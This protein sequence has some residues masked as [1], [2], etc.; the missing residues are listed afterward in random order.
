M[1]KKCLILFKWPNYLNKYLISKLSN[2]Y[3]VEHLFISN[4]KNENFSQTVDKIN[5]TIEYKKIEIVF[6]DV[7]FA[8]FMNFFFIN[9]IKKVKKVMVT[10]DDYAVHE[11]NAITANSCDIILC[12]CPLSTLKYREKGYESYWMPPENDANIFKNYNLNK[13]ID[14]LF[15]GQLRNDRK[16]FIDFLIDNGIKVKI[17]GHDS[18]WVTEEE[19]IKLISKSKIVLNFSKSLGETVTN[20]AA[21]DIYKFHYQ[22]KGRLIQSGLCGTLCISEYSPGQEMIFNEKEIP[23]FR[24]QDEC[25]EI[26]NRYLSN[27]ELLKK[28]S[29]HF[30]SKMLELYEEKVNFKPIYKAIDQP[31]FKKVELVAIPY[32]YVRIAAKQI[33]KKNISIWNMLSSFSQLKQVLKVLEKSSIYVQLLVTIETILNILWYSIKSIKSKN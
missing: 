5:S 1:K 3:E 2:F 10:Y 30:S 19:L 18:N 25:L 7:D 14:V 26:V 20:Y 9:R 17:V 27:N 28:H 15:F 31:T 8:K 11:M 33:I 16:K 12:Q 32:W 23:M 21:A 24:T 4:Y 13:E 6:F 22:L 29:N